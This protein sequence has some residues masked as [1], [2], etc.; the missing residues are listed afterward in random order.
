MFKRRFNGTLF[1]SKLKYREIKH[2]FHVCIIFTQLG[3]GKI[4]F[5]IFLE[6]LLKIK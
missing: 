6:S 2:S 4:N 3:N 1:Q 5:P